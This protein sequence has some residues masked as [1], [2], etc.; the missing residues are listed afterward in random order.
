MLLRTDLN[1]PI[2]PESGH[3]VDDTRIERSLP[4]IRDLAVRGARLV[5]LAHQGDSLDYE[6]FVSTEEH[7]ARLGTKL[8]RPVQWI[9]DVAGPAARHYIASLDEGQI[10]LLDN[11]R[12][13]AE[14]PGP[15][16]QGRATLSLR[17]NQLGAGQNSPGGFPSFDRGRPQHTECKRHERVAG[18]QQCWRKPWSG[19]CP[20]S[21]R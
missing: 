12:I 10:L 19:G 6:N 14:R 17:S 16:D 7:A 21:T 18:T 5:V 4:T 1:C 3:I 11:V 2:D 13:H 8:G 20:V 9:D 15:N